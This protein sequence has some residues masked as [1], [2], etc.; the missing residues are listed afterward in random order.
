MT[1]VS[2][3]STVLGHSHQNPNVEGL[4]L[5]AGKGAKNYLKEKKLIGQNA[6]N[7]NKLERLFTLHIFIIAAKA[8]TLKVIHLG[9]L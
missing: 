2:G 1:L 6:L 3:C 5:A 8:G 9:G 7:R 4:C